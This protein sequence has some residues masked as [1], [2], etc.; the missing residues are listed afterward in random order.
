MAWTHSILDEPTFTTVWQASFRALCLSFD[1]GTLQPRNHHEVERPTSQSAWGGRRQVKFNPNVSIALGLD[2]DWKLHSFDVSESYLSTWVDKPWSGERIK[3]PRSLRNADDRVFPL[4]HLPLDGQTHDDQQDQQPPAA[5]PFLH[6]A[7]QSIQNLFQA[8]MEEDL[9]EGEELSEPVLLRSWYVHHRRVPE[10][11]IPR[12]LEIQGHWRFWATDILDG[13]ND[14]LFPDEDV[15]LALVFPD[16]PRSNNVQ[17]PILFDL[18]VIQG[19]DLP[20]R[21]CLATVIR[22]Q[23]PQQRAERS[24]AISLPHLVSAKYVAARAHLARDC[25]LTECAVRHGRQQLQWD[26]VPAHDA[27]DGQSFIIRRLPNAVGADSSTAPALPHAA[28]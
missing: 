6:E 17:R 24:L 8:L 10:W 18:L 4:R 28:F 1:L 16:P 23:D 7:P 22:F 13:W 12:N 11:N 9:I 2:A 25:H 26:D 15:A 21:A 3:Q 14:Q 19:L 5:G 20:R 27:R